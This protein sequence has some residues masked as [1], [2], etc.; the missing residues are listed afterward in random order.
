VN[1]L[2]L[3]SPTARANASEPRNVYTTATVCHLSI[4]RVQYR[5]PH[6]RSPRALGA[7]TGALPPSGT[8]A[9]VAP[10]ADPPKDSPETLERFHSHIE[11]VDLIARQLIREVGRA[12]ELDD[13]RAM[14]HQ[15]LLEAARRFDEG[16]GVSFRRFANY[17][18]RG[19]MLDGIRKSSPLPRRAYA[20]IRALEA[21]LLVSEGAAEDAA[22]ASAAMGSDPVE[23]DRRLTDHLSDMATA[24][25]IG[26]LA[27]TA[28]GED[29]EPTVVDIGTS[30]EEA[31]AQAELKEVVAEA[32][33]HLPEDERALVRRHYLEGERFD[34]VAA[35]LG[36][37]KSWGSRLHARAITRLTKRL[38]AK[39]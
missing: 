11:L 6:A 29:G 32:L 18:V 15:G 10:V 3:R 28:V 17:R 7:G 31:F 27:P 39:S 16:R 19:A 21:A 24:M 30:P 25:A 23:A 5:T 37:S 33:E 1:G 38:R 20:R 13:L 34:H 36:L 9:T 22:A 35:S 2:P 26:L 14:G 8:A 4:G 12:V